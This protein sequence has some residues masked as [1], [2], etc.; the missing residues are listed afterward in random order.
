MFPLPISTYIYIAIALGTAFITHRVDGYYSEKEKLEAV[1]HVVE[2]QTKVVN[3]QAIISQQTQKDKDDLQT[4]YDNAIA[5]LRGLRNTNLSAGQP[6]ATAIPSQGLRL[7][8]SDAEVLIG[9]A[10]QCQ[11]S[12]I[13]RNDVINKYNA[14]MVSK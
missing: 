11:T 6:S 13:E 14:L 3:D 10:R 12:E 9:F 8:E 7:L 5:Q 4:R 2:V 1:Q